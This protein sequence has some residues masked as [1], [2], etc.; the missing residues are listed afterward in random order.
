MCLAFLAKAN[1]TFVRQTRRRTRL[2][3]VRHAM[4][5]QHILCQLAESDATNRRRGTGK[6]AIDHIR[7]KPQRLEHLR[8]AIRRERRDSH[9][10]EN[11]E[12]PFLHCRAI[13]RL[14]LRGQ[15]TFHVSIR[16]A[17]CRF[18]EQRRNGLERQPRKYRFGAVTDQRRHVMLLHDISRLDHDA[19][20]RAKTCAHEMLTDRA[21]RQQCR[22][23]HTLGARLAIADDQQ[24]RAFLCDR[25]STPAECIE[26]R[27]QRFGTGTRGPGGI[28]RD[29]FE[30]GEIAQLLHLFRQQHR[31]LHTQHACVRRLLF[32]RRSTL[33]KMH[34]QRHHHRFAQ[35]VNRRIGDLRE[36]LTQEVI[37]WRHF[38]RQYRKWRVITHAPHNFG[39]S[40]CHRLEDHAQIFVAVPERELQRSQ[41][42][43]RLHQRLHA[44]L[45]RKRRHVL[46]NPSTIRTTSGNF[47]LGGEVTHDTP[48]RRV[49]QQH[50]ARTEFSALDNV[51]R[52]EIDD[53][54]FR[55][56]D[57]HAVRADFVPA[58]TQSV[59]IER[60]S[61]LHAIA[62][63][64][65]RRSIPRFNHALVVFVERLHRR[66]HVGILLPCL[67]HQHHH[68]VNRTASRAHQ[69]F[70]RVVETRGVAAARADRIAKARAIRAELR[71]IEQPAPHRHCV[72][73]SPQRID[74]AVVAEHAERLRQL[75]ARQ[76]VG[77]VALMKYGDRRFERRIEQIGIELRQL[78]AAE[79]PLVHDRATGE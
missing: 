18:R 52:I 49:N 43:A 17:V 79:Q 37:Q 70:E 58:R 76:R 21:Q 51:A 30:A 10:G 34:A 62:V 74:L 55:A 22:N 8:P 57:N 20:F 65:R 11:L 38:V 3:T 31:M 27:F 73:I 25:L 40:A 47:A 56:R 53:T 5:R 45:R 41:L 6:A 48:T 75:P 78:S 26:C 12:Q 16:L 23:R 32:K 33:T 2:D 9:F 71:R 13:L 77:G 69:Q 64:Q 50:A 63:R 1:A 46:L 42:L 60:D 36:A 4:T 7:T 24:T 35:R 66:L 39:R 14:C 19:D 68:R 67:R 29:G 15:R 72:A 61:D 44:V 59:A 28:E 54:H